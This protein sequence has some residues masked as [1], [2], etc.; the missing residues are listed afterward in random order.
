MRE[1]NRS[2][3]A[4]GYSG[5]SPERLKLH[6]KHQ[7]DFD[8]MT[9]KASTGPC[10]GEYYGL[11]WPCWGTPELKHPGTGFLYNTAVPVKEGG[12]GFRARWGVEREGVS[13][14]AN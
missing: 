5:Q 11:P 2:C 12:S 8:P 13:L 14:L 7:A 4:I 3:F 10:A 9:L 1:I 6:A